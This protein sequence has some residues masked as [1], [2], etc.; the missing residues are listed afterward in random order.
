M[1]LPLTGPISLSQVNTELGRATGTTI[2][3]GDAEVR[4]LAGVAT[5]AIGLGAL[6]GKSAQFTH[7]ITSHQQELNLHTYLQGQGWD[8]TNKVE[9]TVASGIYIWSD[10]TTTPAL[11]MG[12]V[13][14][15]GLTLVNRGFIMGKGGDGGYQLTDRTSYV[16]PTSGG[17][18]IGL[19]GP[20]TIDNAAGYI[21]GGG[22]GGAA[23]TGSVLAFFVTPV[24]SPGGG[25]AGGGRGG[26]MPYG[27]TSSLVMGAFGLG[28]AIGQ[29]GS[30][31]TNSNNFA[32]ETIPSH[33]GAG[34][35]GG[36]GVTT[37]G[38]L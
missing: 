20:I 38:G 1:A 32:G 7:T 13:F 14:P 24:H 10:T 35:A 17:P 2:S 36:A 22:G 34:G 19:T 25:G 8:G 4:G 16:A 12:G 9:V 30:V 31:A 21:G 11:D 27:D 6:R 3:L 26:A 37:G 5:G 28:G 33:G 18:A 23:S 29:P 15:G